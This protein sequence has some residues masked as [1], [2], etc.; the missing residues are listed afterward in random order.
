MLIVCTSFPIRVCWRDKEIEPGLCTLTAVILTW[1]RE[2]R[3]RSARLQTHFESGCHVS[4]PGL[5]FTPRH[6]RYAS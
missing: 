5:R 4:E 2:G 6:A 1:T 3:W